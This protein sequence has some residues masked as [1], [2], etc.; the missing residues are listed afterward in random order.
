MQSGDGR[1]SWYMLAVYLHV[2]WW[3]DMIDGTMDK[4]LGAEV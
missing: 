4:K 2:P 3:Y 1:S